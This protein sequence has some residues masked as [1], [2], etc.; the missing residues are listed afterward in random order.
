[1]KPLFSAA[2]LA[3]VL[4]I[5]SGCVVSDRYLITANATNALAHVPESERAATAVPARRKKDGKAV[6]VRGST[7]DLRG[8][9][10]VGDDV[11]VTA[12]LR[13][14]MVVA[15][16]ALT[17]VG[18]AIS[19][20]GTIVFFSFPSGQRHWVGGGLSLSAEAIMLTGTGLWIAGQ[21]GHPQELPP[22]SAGIRYLSP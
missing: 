4:L 9:N 18:T 10:A 22:A 14:K 2:A 6:F 11:E 16:Q 20:A 1:M 15:G 13:S 21:A 8:S 19:V 17:W 3:A 12:G 7:V 5:A